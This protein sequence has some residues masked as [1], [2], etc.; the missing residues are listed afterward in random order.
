RSDDLR[1]SSRFQRLDGFLGWTWHHIGSRQRCVFERSAKS[2]RNPAG[3]GDDCCLANDFR[4]RPTARDR[5]CS[6]RKS[7]T[8]SLDHVVEFLS[9]L[10][11][12]NRLGPHL[13]ASLLA[14]TADDHSAATNNLT[15]HSTWGSSV[16]LGNW[17]RDI[18]HLVAPWCLPGASRCL[19]YFS[20]R[21][22]KG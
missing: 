4:H 21:R 14:V 15:H 8:V 17:R 2:A 5:I 12:S 18:F 20:K 9:P 13:P 19:D 1:A 7:A 16:R 6:G 11:R 22:R 10:S 3:A